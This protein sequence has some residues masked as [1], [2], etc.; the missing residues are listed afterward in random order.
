M[1]RASVLTNNG[2]IEGGSSSGI[3]G[4]GVEIGHPT[5]GNV[6][7][8]DGTIRG[9]FGPNNGSN[10]LGGVG[11]YVRQGTDLITNNNLVEGGIGAL[12]I[13]TNTATVDLNLINSGTIRAGARPGKCDQ[14]FYR[15][16]DRQYHAGASGH[17]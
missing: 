14:P 4:S 16:Y 5:G 2:T 1:V 7:T 17:R 13:V 10:L 15:R 8:N 9:G 11:I 12:A 6:L 3:G